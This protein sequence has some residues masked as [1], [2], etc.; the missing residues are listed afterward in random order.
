LLEPLEEPALHAL[1]LTLSDGFSFV[2]AFRSIAP[3]EGVAPTSDPFGTVVERGETSD[4]Q[5]RGP[6]HVW[7]RGTI[8]RCEYVALTGVSEWTGPNDLADLIRKGLLEPTGGH[9]WRAPCRV[10]DETR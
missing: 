9:G 1:A 8:A 10:R 2:I 5:C 3:R 7:Q 4:R 6:L